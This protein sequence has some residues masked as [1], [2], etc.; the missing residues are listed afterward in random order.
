[1]KICD[2]AIHI[3]DYDYFKKTVEE[4]AKGDYIMSWKYRKKINILPGFRLNLSK[5][6]MSATIGMKGFNI[7]TGRNGTYLNT[8]IPGTGIYDRI[9]LDGKSGNTSQE[10][11]FSDNDTPVK[12][13]PHS[14]D[15]TI[16][17]KSLQPQLM[18]SD[19]MYGLKDAIIKARE[20][21]AELKDESDKAN[22]QKKIALFW[23]VTSYVFIFGMFFKWFRK[24]YNN[25]MQ[26]ARDASDA[27][28]NFR[29]DISFDLDA[30][31]LNE[32]TAL[33]NTFD[34]LSSV[35]RIWGITTQ[36]TI[37]RVKERSAASI[38]IT[39]TP[40]QFSRSS[41]DYL[42]AKYEALRLRTANGGDLYVYPGFMVMPGLQRD[43]FAIIDFRDIEMEY[44][45]QRFVETDMVPSDVKIVDYTWRYVNKSGTP[46]R[47]YANNPKIPIALYYELVLKSEKGLHEYF[48]F[49]DAETAGRFC[50]ALNQ[51]K[52]SL[53]QMKWEAEVK[54][55]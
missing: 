2:G 36:K 9:R 49:S 21:K 37:D 54:T 48:Q 14:D 45:V 40:V 30:S 23:L 10:P 38:N 27:Y 5:T 19:G 3:Q 20:T 15:G 35:W 33:E 12:I 13:P 55:M 29:L 16:E 26:D 50:V 34:K 8:G 18:T 31:S 24:N 28:R 4:Q 22:G 51:Y 1:L 53:K 46:D 42:N 7:N 47:R 41:L 25:R 11:P 44:H 32:Y 17:I 52:N 6:G 39:R 43:D